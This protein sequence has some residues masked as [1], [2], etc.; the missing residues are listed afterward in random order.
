MQIS[1]DKGKKWQDCEFVSDIKKYTWVQWEFNTNIV[2][3]GEYN[4]WCR[5]IS[6]KNKQIDNINDQ[7]NLRGLNN[8]SIYKK[9]YLI[10]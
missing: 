8:N 10:S 4:I 6:N 5:A 9:K 1:L 3:E 7:W 2:I